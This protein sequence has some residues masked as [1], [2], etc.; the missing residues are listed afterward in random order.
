M[1]VKQ[2][3]VSTVLAAHHR[4]AVIQLH[5]HQGWGLRK[6]LVV[7]MQHQ[8]IEQKHLVPGR[9]EGLGNDL[10]GGMERKVKDHSARV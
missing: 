1:S 4:V 2:S 5:H 9:G 6:L 3:A 7:S 8:V 10:E